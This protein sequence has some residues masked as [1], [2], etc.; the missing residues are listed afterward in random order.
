MRITAYTKDEGE[1]EQDNL[2]IE[3][4]KTYQT[5]KEF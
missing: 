4:I 3:E 2:S 5:P 1:I